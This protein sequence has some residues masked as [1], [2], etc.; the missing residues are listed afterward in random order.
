MIRPLRTEDLHTAVSIWYSASIKAHNFISDEYWRSQKNNMR[1]LYLPNCD[2]W[3]FEDES[4]ILGFISYYKGEIPAI[5]VDPS[6]QSQGIGTNLL[7]FLKQKYSKLNLAV[8]KE[9]E[10]THQFYI[11]HGFKDIE[12]T[13]C[14]HTGH[15]QIVMYWKARS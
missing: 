3:V 9:N 15:R 1:D 6:A 5:F 7:N 12:E 4:S 14:E 11:R 10:K 13:V 2:T 8:Y